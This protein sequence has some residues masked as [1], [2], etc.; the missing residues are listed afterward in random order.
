MGKIA[1][2]PVSFFMSADPAGV[3]SAAGG[4]DLERPDCMEIPVAG[5]H[6]ALSAKRTPAGG[7]GHPPASS[8]PASDAWGAEGINLQDV[9]ALPRS[10]RSGE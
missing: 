8:P 10:R 1:G 7:S 5:F 6:P 4:A 2:S 3:S 9:D